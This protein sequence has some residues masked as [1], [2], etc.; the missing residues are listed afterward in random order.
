MACGQDAHVR[1]ASGLVFKNLDCTQRVFKP[2]LE[3]RQE[4]GTFI[5]VCV[6]QLPKRLAHE[7]INGDPAKMASA[8]Q[9]IED[10]LVQPFDQRI[11]DPSA[12]QKQATV[13]SRIM[14]SWSCGETVCAGAASHDW[15]CRTSST[16]F[17]DCRI[18]EIPKI[19][20]IPFMG[21]DRLR[22]Q[23]ELVARQHD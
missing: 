1:F 5:R 14:L 16:G 15:S 19:D 2:E 21:V 22:A 9:L 6:D 12:S 13:S 18:A 10:G 7:R 17:P 4:F 11:D 3:N 8:E 20:I 23:R